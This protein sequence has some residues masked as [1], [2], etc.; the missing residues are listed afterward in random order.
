MKNY[1]F[2]H[3]SAGELLRQEQ[4]RSEPGFGEIIKKHINNGTIVPDE[5]TCSLIERVSFFINY[6]EIIF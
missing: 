2:V 1:G 4:Q 6:M 5:I 3:L